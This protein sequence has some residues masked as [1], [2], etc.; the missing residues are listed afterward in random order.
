MP[1]DENSPQ[2]TSDFWYVESDGGGPYICQNG[3]GL[4]ATI[5]CQSWKRNGGTIDWQRA[6]L[7][8]AAP[9]LL[10][11]CKQLLV[12]VE[13]NCD[14]SEAR[15]VCKIGRA[16]IE[17]AKLPGSRKKQTTLGENHGDSVD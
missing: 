2:R 11:A 9:K 6:H 5:A 8:K 13:K 1:R 3:E 4:I 16:A 17:S 15:E 10:E 12:A 14:L 7:M